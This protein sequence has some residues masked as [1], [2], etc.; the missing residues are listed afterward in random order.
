[1]QSP[2][3]AFILNLWIMR[4]VDEVYLQSKVPARITQLECDMI[5]TTPQMTEAQIAM[6]VV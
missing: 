4:K 3:Y 5:L 2:A 6:H 1:M